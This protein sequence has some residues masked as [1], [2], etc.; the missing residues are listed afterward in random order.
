MDRKMKQTIVGASVVVAIIIICVVLVIKDKMTPS[1]EHMELTEYYQVKQDEILVFMENYQYEKTG[2]YIDNTVYIDYDT[3]EQYINKRFYWDNNENLLIYTTPTDIIKV[4]AGEKDY[5]V[6]KS[7][8]KT[9]YQVVRVKGDQVYVALEFVKKYSNVEYEVFLEPNRVVL[10]CNWGKQFQ[11]AEAGENLSVRVEPDIKSA[12]LEDVEVGEL[13]VFVDEGAQENGFVKVMTTSGVIGYAR[14]KYLLDG[15]YVVLENEYKEPEYTSIKKKGTIN[16]VWHQV[17]SKSSND[18]LLSMVDGT[19]GINVISPTWFSIANENGEI[20]SLASEKYVK[21]A[22]KLGMDVWALV[23]DFNKE[24]DKPKLFGRTSSREK[25]SNE[26]IAAAIRYDLDGLNIDF[27]QIKADYSKSYIQFLREL[28]VKC[29]NNGLILSIDNYIPAAYNKFYDREEQGIIADYIICMAYDE[30]FSGSEESGSVSSIDYVTQSLADT[31]KEVPTEKI[32]MALPFYTRLWRETKDG[33]K[34]KVSSEAYSMVKAEKL[35]QNKNV[36]LEWNGEIG[37]YYGQYQ[38][39]GATFKMWLEDEKSYE[40]KLKAV[41]SE[42]IAG[43]AAWKLGLEKQSIW[44]II[45][46]YATK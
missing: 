39:E 10:T 24:I 17:F 35:L 26:L 33:D 18:D 23:D 3:V 30:H 27:E 12:I 38:E 46:K 16:M 42:P 25:L 5:V 32:I 4:T 43:V 2:L 21:Q 45:A 20:T 34:V 41:F 31:K 14:E 1:D 44:N 36:T 11:Y 37:Q 6:N 8:E 9:D 22:H 13:V 29:R 40:T 15:E 19:T 7:E 28:S